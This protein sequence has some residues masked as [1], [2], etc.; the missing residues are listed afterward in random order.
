[1]A[2]RRTSSLLVVG[3]CAVLASV[4]GAVAKD[5]I[6]AEFLKQYPWLPWLLLAVVV[7]VL[8]WWFVQQ[9]RV[10]E[11]EEIPADQLKRK[12]LKGNRDRM[13][14][15]VRYHWIEGVLD[16]SLYKVARVDLGLV[17]KPDAVEPL[18]VVVQQAEQEP[19]TLPAGTRLSSVF[20]QQIG[21]LL[22]L[23]A[24][25][26]G[27]TT[28]LL[29]LA[30]ELLDRAET[31]KGL[32]IPVVFN[33]SSWAVKGLPLA[34]WLRDEL[35]SSYNVSRKI[36]E[37]WIATEAVLPLLDGLDEVAADKR[38]ACVEAVNTFHSHHNQPLVVCS[39]EA[40]YASLTK[41]LS[42]AVAVR[43]QPLGHEEVRGYL[44][45][46]GEPLKAVLTALETE[47]ELWELLDTPLMLSIAALA[48]QGASPAD[49]VLEGSLEARYQ[50]VFSRYVEV[51]FERRGKQSRYSR[52][53]TLGWLRWLGASLVSQSQSVF[54]LENLRPVWLSTWSRQQWARLL[55]G[56]VAGLVV[57][58]VFG[59]VFGLGSGLVFGLFV[60]L[61][62]GLGV[63][64]PVDALRWSWS[65]VRSGF[66][67]SLVGGLFVGL[68]VGLVGG[69]IFG[70]VFGLFVGLFVG[71]GGGLFVGLGGGLVIGLG[72]GFVGSEVTTRSTPNEGTRRSQRNAMLSVLVV[73][74]LCVVLFGG[75]SVGLGTG[76]GGLGV[77]LG[78]GLVIGLVIGLGN[79]GAFV[80]QH[81][82][83]R[84]LLWK[85]G[86]A[87][88]NY[89][90]FLES[91]KD[92]IFLR[93]AGGGY[94]FIHRSL[95][96]YFAAL[97]EDDIRRFSSEKANKQRRGGLSP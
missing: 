77:G 14:E 7:G 36:A 71:L 3:L 42:L 94:I 43:V 9:E 30:Q 31:D 89:V 78:V 16:R 53:Q 44:E 12:Q 93:R 32:Q 37:G 2:R 46:A 95:L 58:P 13:I 48:Y 4:I 68:V 17:T 55:R 88:L 69:L 6:P 91:A 26:S 50:Q 73:V 74:V 21:Q 66:K 45:E 61:G 96:E 28:L 70:L 35:Q 59:L 97:S 52:E 87:P 29:E 83:L 22:I 86:H 67:D 33:L 65:S 15:R 8:V 56:L 20:D 92:L 54:H 57:G 41:R 85:Y 34:D 24:P 19:E 75:L 51:M 82:S 38:E 80:V 49:L 84:F 5:T 72:G 60:G 25:G 79:G 11:A 76:L 62:G 23:G 10:K 27:K 18:S 81:F 90:R 39:R 63:R 64:R 40:D 1:M 47:T